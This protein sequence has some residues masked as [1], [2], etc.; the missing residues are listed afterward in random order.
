MAIKKQFTKQEI[1][2][3]FLALYPD[4]YINLEKGDYW[5][6]FQA[7]GKCYNYRYCVNLYDIAEKLNLATNDEISAMKKAAGYYS[8]Q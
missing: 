8:Y 2:K 6:A 5:V 7:N 1:E 4:G 3:R